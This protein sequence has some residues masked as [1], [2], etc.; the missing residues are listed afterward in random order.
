MKNAI[1]NISYRGKDDFKLPEGSEI[2]KK[3]ISIHIEEIENGFIISK[4]YQLEVL[5]GDDIRH[6]YLTK[7]FYSK[8]NPMKN[9]DLK[10]TKEE[11]L[12]LADKL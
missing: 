10:L 2:I 7:K 3:N 8:K 5:R 1:K 11:D 9:L 4:E 12:S 6:E